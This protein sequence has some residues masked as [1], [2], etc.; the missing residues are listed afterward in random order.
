M[1][2]IL[3]VGPRRNDRA[4]P[5]SLPLCFLRFSVFSVPVFKQASSNPQHLRALLTKPPTRLLRAFGETASTELGC[6][7]C[8]QN[9]CIRTIGYMSIDYALSLHTSSPSRLGLYWWMATAFQRSFSTGKSAHA[10]GVKRCA[11]HPR[12]GGCCCAPP[13][14]KVYTIY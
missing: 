8:M 14:P 9:E 10:L 7:G 3:S 6:V 4:A 1:C 5:S 12:R 11:T 13:D 2:C